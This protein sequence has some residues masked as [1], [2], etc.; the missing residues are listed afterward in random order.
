[1]KRLAALAPRLKLVLG[2]HNVPFAQPSV[3]PRLVTAIETV[4]A[5]KVSPEPQDAGKA[6]YR[7]DGISFLLSAHALEGK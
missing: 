2:Q 6:I 5:G 3:L 4:R 1:V 7:Y